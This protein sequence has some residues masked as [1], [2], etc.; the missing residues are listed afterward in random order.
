M[1]SQFYNRYIPPKRVASD[2]NEASRP[3]KKRKKSKIKADKSQQQTAPTPGPPDDAVA[4]G[5]NP[6]N[7][8]AQNEV[9]FRSRHKNVLSKFKKA[10]KV[11]DKLEDGEAASE[12]DVSVPGQ[13]RENDLHF[14]GLEP[15][16]LPE[17][18]GPK[19]S[20]SAFSAL[21]EWLQSPTFVPTTSTTSLDELPIDEKIRSS[22]QNKGYSTAFAIQSAILPMLLPSPH[23]YSGDI[24]ISAATGSGKTLAYALPMIEAL[25]SEPVTKLRGLIVVPTRELV[26]Q[27]KETL[28]L[29]RGGSGLKIGTAVGSRSLK[30]ERALLIHKGRRFDPGAYK[31]DQEKEIEEEKWMDWES[32][33]QFGPDDDP[34]L[35]PKCIV[36][37]TSMVDILVCTPGRLVEHIQS[38]TGFTLE[39]VQWLVIDE[40]DR[41][42][43][44][45][46]QQWIDVVMPALEYLPPLNPLDQQVSTRRHLLHHQREVRKIILSATMTR[47]ISKLTALKLKRPRLVVLEGQSTNGVSQHG[48]DSHEVQTGEKAQLPS[49][50]QETG[51]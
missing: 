3:I 36:Q 37:Y 39:D 47:D 40:A 26:N 13:N 18:S 41:L 12:M 8:S 42:L 11:S 9:G 14:H 19:P 51:K 17:Q 2:D 21:P 43:D 35:P 34:C 22:L 27:V 16:P 10:T 32:D 50:L 25:R 44:E 7:Q 15:L 49:T 46:F 48:A 6:E 45:S 29:Y 28:E 1:A 24:C 30:D 23:R 38:T 4:G 31:A 20:V 5:I 33:K